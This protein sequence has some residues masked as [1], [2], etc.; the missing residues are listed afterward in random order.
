MVTA[1]GRAKLLD[2]GLAKFLAPAASDPE[3]AT[4]ARETSP[5]MTLGTAGY[6]A[7]EQALGKEVDA[8][9]DLF[10]LGVVLYEMATG[11]SPFRGETLA[12][13][14]DSLLNDAPP[15]PLSAN[16]D[17]PTDLVRVIERA[18]EKE[19]KRR[20]GSAGELVSE[21]KGVAASRPSRTRRLSIAVL[22]FRDLSPERD[23]DYF[24]QG[25][26][27]ELINTLA[28]IRG[29]RVLARTSA[30]ALQGQG[31]DVR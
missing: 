6:M 14:F 2:F 19:P 13:F 8:R 31:L 5:G 20:Y 22:P 16:P 23:Q 25:L 18:L 3:S 28:A 30:F 12:A 24:C 27:E 1:E 21:L 10:A 29:L 4:M 26:S 11:K 7:P 15:S 17:L 9:A